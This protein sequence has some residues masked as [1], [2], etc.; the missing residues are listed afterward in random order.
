MTGDLGMTATEVH[1]VSEALA[2]AG[3]VSWL[4]GG[5]GVDALVGRQTRRHRDLDLAFDAGYEAVA[6]EALGRLGYVLE[7]DWRPVRFE[8]AAPHSRYVDMH[9]VVLD[10]QGNGVQAGPDHSTFV[11][12]ATSFTTGQIEGR[13]ISCIAA[14]LQLRFHSGYDPRDVDL[15]DIAHLRQVAARAQGADVRTG[16]LDVVRERCTPQ[17][18]SR[19]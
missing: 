12:P 10:D 16:V 19:G 8:L 3:C 4:G 2:D 14:E 6:I 7:T 17:G 5:W 9:P 1:R 11:Y 18:P 13:A 15:A